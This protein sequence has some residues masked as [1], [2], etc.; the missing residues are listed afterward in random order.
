LE[1]NTLR[2]PRDKKLA[3][4]LVNYSCKIQPGE[5]CL[6]HAT[7]TPVEFV[8]ELVNAVYAAKGFP[9]VQFETE[10]IERALRIGGSKE[11]Y[12][13][14]TEIEKYQMG[15]MDAFIGVRGPA[16]PKEMSDLPEGSNGLYMKEFYEPV[17]FKVRVPHTKWVVLRYP[18]ESMAMQAN[19]STLKFEEYYY[20]VTTG[21]DYDKM[22]KAMDTVVDFMSKADKVHILGPDT[23]LKFSIK[24]IGAVKCSG[25][26]NIPDGEVYS[27]PVKDSI[28]G[29]ISYN[30][31][32]S[33][34]GFT[35]TDVKLEFE[36]GKIVKATSNDNDRI[37]KIFDT[38]EG[39]RY[40][41][42]F[43]LGCNPEINFPMDNI[44][45]DEKIAGSFHFT[46]G[47]AYDDADNGNK[48]AVHWDL[49]CIQT[50]E[51]GGGEIWIDNELIRKDGIFLHKDFKALNPENLKG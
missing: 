10:R 3:E 14:K 38:D 31:P 26:M 32:S 8:E 6:I 49:V 34:L 33:Y 5:N 20:K 45:F 22:S 30:A 43:A 1:E 25:E 23:D 2:D 16:N 41:G 42:E 13:L 47:A 24:N 17:H 12:K 15:E 51:Y 50:P 27:C 9:I 40:V 21:V 39:A 7:D 37:N 19:M 11:S 44:L 36:K 48:S 4:L 35:F 28:E 46:P 18:T 29:H